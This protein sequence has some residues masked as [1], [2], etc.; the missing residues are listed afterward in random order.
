MSAFGGKSGRFFMHPNM[1]AND[2]K[3]TSPRKRALGCKLRISRG[4]YI[5]MNRFSFPVSLWRLRLSTRIAG[6]TIWLG[7]G[8]PFLSR[9]LQLRYSV[10]PVRAAIILLSGWSPWSAG[11]RANLP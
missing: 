6:R 5:G 10:P 1:A 7:K 11:Q 4:P 2:P 9:V 3:R 8:T